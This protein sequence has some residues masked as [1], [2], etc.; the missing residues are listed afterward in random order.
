MQISLIYNDG[1]A[2]AGAFLRSCGCALQAR[3]STGVSDDG[4]T[5]ARNRDG[6]TQTA[7][8]RLVLLVC[9]DVNGMRAKR[10]F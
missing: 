10:Q 8:A 4:S 9:L 1:G 7:C 5:A 2:G 3:Q 6:K